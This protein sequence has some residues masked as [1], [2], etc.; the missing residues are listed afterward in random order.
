MSIINLLYSKY[1]TISSFNNFSIVS[2]LLWNIELDLFVILLATSNFAALG[3]SLKDWH[4][5]ILDFDIL[6]VTFAFQEV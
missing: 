1:L 5:L 2:I 3:D 6:F 4:Q